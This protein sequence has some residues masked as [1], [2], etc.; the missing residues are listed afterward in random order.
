M[1]KNLHTAAYWRAQ[2][3]NAFSLGLI[4]G[5]FGGLFLMAFISW[6]DK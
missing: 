3:W 4:I 2:F 6:I 1:T 5:T